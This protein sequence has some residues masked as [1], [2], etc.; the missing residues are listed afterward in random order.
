MNRAHGE[1]YGPAHRWVSNLEKPLKKQGLT[2][3]EILFSL[4][5]DVLI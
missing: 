4:A 5:S 2:F 1:A 3:L